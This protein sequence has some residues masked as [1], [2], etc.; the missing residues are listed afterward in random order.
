MIFNA[1]CYNVE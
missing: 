1:D